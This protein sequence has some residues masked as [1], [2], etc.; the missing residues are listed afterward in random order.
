[1]TACDDWLAVDSSQLKDPS[2]QAEMES[3]SLVQQ[4]LSQWQDGEALKLESLLMDMKAKLADTRIS[5]QVFN[6]DIESAEKEDEKRVE[7]AKVQEKIEE[8]KA[9]L[10]KA[11]SIMEEIKQGRTML[12]GEEAA[13]ILDDIVDSVAIICDSREE[14]K[15][16]FNQPK[17]EEERLSV[18]MLLRKTKQQRR[19]ESDVESTNS[20]IA[21]SEGKQKGER[22]EKEKEKG[23]SYPY[24]QE[25]SGCATEDLPRARSRK[26]KAGR[27]S[28]RIKVIRQIPPLVGGARQE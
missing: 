6:E 3:A 16:L 18:D 20:T 23:E 17:K 8:A 28:G 10:E 13:A 27:I 19:C 21:G 1:M 11:E 9:S 24:S 12:D 2:L 15:R 14:Y 4:P 26:Q 5:Q 22:K 25:C 7:I